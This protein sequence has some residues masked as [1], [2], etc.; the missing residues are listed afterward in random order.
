MRN[1]FCEFP[2]DQKKPE[3][4]EFGAL[5]PC[6][7]SRFQ[8]P[9]LT[10]P[11]LVS[12]S[13]H[14]KRLH[15]ILFDFVGSNFQRSLVKRVPNGKHS[16]SQMRGT[17]L[18]NFCAPMCC[19]VLF[20]S[21]NNASAQPCPDGNLYVMWEHLWPSK[22]E[23]VSRLW[24]MASAFSKLTLLLDVINPRQSISQY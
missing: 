24:L 15:R 17:I 10:L 22:I 5:Q 14:E 9:T 23:P 13:Q 4:C 7:P 2:A 1:G 12:T 8:V 18:D 3:P 20:R 21:M 6:I 16:P 19:Q 11:D